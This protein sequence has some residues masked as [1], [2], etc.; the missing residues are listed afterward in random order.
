MD[1]LRVIATKDV[2]QE[3][4]ATLLSE[5]NAVLPVKEAGRLHLY[6]ADPPSY[7]EIIGRVAVWAPLSIAAS[8]FLAQLAKRAADAI[9]DDRKRIWRSTLDVLGR[10]TEPLAR[11][12][13]ALVRVRGALHAR[14]SVGLGIEIG[15]P[16][17]P[18]MLW[19]SSDDEAEVAWYVALLVVN[20]EKIVS[21]LQE[22]FAAGRS[23]LGPILLSAT[24]SGVL[25]MRWTDRDTMRLRETTLS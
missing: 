24:S 6:S 11:V 20:A 18:P 1:V 10:V 13:Q 17:W 2:P 3:E 4:L 15:S 5:L 22:E 23:P 12:A 14:T 21:T 16:S 8:A 9:W 25:T 19:V 7:I